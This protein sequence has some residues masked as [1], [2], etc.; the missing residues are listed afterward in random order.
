MVHFGANETD[1]PIVI[2]ATLLTTDGEDLAVPADE[3]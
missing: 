1:E 2:V 3:D